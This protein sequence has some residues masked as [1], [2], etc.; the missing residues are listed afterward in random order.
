[1]SDPSSSSVSSEMQ[2]MLEQHKNPQQN[3]SPQ[4]PATSQSQYS[5][6]AKSAYSVKSK[7][8]HMMQRNIMIFIAVLIVIVFIY[9]WVKSRSQSFTGP[10]KSIGNPKNRMFGMY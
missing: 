1:M 9:M 2:S 3:P 4:Q 6:P 10:P 5:V 8:E 7:D